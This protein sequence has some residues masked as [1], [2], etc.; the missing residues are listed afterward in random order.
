MSVIRVGSN[1][2]YA[3]GWDEIFGKGKGKGK[4]KAK[5]KAAGKKTFAAKK[6][7]KK[8]AGKKR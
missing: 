6:T 3:A 8:K 5:A 7:A 2:N 4:S 1:G